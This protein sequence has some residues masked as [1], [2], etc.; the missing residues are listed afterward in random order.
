MTPRHHLQLDQTT[1]RWCIVPEGHGRTRDATFME[2]HTGPSGNPSTEASASL[3]EET[4]VSPRPMIPHRR[5]TSARPAEVQPARCNVGAVTPNCHTLIQALSWAMDDKT[6]QV[7]VPQHRLG[8][9][10]LCVAGPMQHQAGRMHDTAATARR[11]MMTRPAAPNT[12]PSDDGEVACAGVWSTGNEDPSARALRSSSPMWLSLPRGSDELGNTGFSASPPEPSISETLSERQSINPPIFGGH[13]CLQITLLQEL[14]VGPLSFASKLLTQ[15]M[16]RSGLLSCGLVMVAYSDCWRILG[17][18][19]FAIIVPEN[20]TCTIIIDTEQ[21]IHDIAQHIGTEPSTGTVAEGI[22]GGEVGRTFEDHTNPIDDK[23]VTAQ[24]AKGEQHV[25]L[26]QLIAK[27]PQLRDISTIQ[28]RNELK[29]PRDKNQRLINSMKEDFDCLREGLNIYKIPTF[30]RIPQRLKVIHDQIFWS[31]KN[32]LLNLKGMRLGFCISLQGATVAEAK[33][34]ENPSKKN[35]NLRQR[36]NN[37][38]RK[39]TKQKHNTSVEH[40]QGLSGPVDFETVTNESNPDPQ[41]SSRSDM[42]SKK[43]Q[44]IVKNISEKSTYVS[45][46]TETEAQNIPHLMMDCSTSQE[47]MKSWNR[48]IVKDLKD[49]YAKLLYRDEEGYRHRHETYK[50]LILQTVDFLYKH[51][52]I[53]VGLFKSFYDTDQILESAG[54][55]IVW[56]FI[57]AKEDRVLDFSWNI[58][59]YIDSWYS[60]HSRNMHEVLDQ[61]QKTK[62]E[63]AAHQHLFHLRA[64]SHVGTRGWMTRAHAWRKTLF[65]RNKTVKNNITLHKYLERHS[66]NDP[67]EAYEV[68]ICLIEM[69]RHLDYDES[70]SY[71]AWKARRIEWRSISQLLGFIQENYQEVFLQI[72][73]EDIQLEDKL[74]LLRSSSQFLGKLENIRI[75]L[76][77]YIPSRGIWVSDLKLQQPRKSSMTCLEE[78]NLIYE[79]NGKGGER[80]K[81]GF[82][83]KR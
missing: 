47:V 40:P 73:H 8:L 41:D 27:I 38:Q 19:I 26:Q 45:A 16:I 68:Q 2:D 62:F 46:R 52:M 53:D 81:S 83:L 23:W 32:D 60:S 56:Y 29:D 77:E 48:G 10:E 71:N 15:N 58:N 31:M 57:L 35:P 55:N 3:I 7:I 82:Y 59:F 6:R 34:S 78:L 4:C 66:D 22:T 33:I 36:K 70:L 42:E 79:F 63:Y 14:I 9:Y 1:L 69:I 25:D 49:I 13:L 44:N 37:F 18:S 74:E 61:K 80:P 54:K 24:K 28:A 39:L 43:L 65:G 5:P 12:S 11:H 72:S 67:Q 75:Y 51:E 30:S 76:N 21:A 17:L 20:I 50:R 64:W